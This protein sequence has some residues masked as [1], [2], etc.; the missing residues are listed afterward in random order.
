MNSFF[1]LSDIISKSIADAEN[2]GHLDPDSTPELHLQRALSYIKCGKTLKRADNSIVL[3][4]NIS[5][6]AC[7]VGQREVRDRQ[8]SADQ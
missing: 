8:G 3:L 2:A 5:M 6:Y 4:E 1:V 7:R